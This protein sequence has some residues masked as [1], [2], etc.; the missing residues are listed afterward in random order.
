M[1]SNMHQMDKMSTQEPQSPHIRV[2]A[3]TVI[4]HLGSLN[5]EIWLKDQRLV[6]EACRSTPQITRP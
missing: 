4:R 6:I 5:T 2:E 3:S 1:V